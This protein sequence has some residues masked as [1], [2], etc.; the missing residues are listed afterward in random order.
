MN[1]ADALF[2]AD[3]GKPLVDQTG[4]PG[5]GKQRRSYFIAFL[6]AAVVVLAA[7]VGYYKF[8]LPDGV[9]AVVNTET[10]TLSELDAAVTRMRGTAGNASDGLRYQAL[11]ELIAERLV[12]QEAGKAGIRLSKEEADSAAR[13]AQAASGLDDAAFS[14]E[15]KVLYGSMQDF[16]KALERRLVIN[17]FIAERVVPRGADPQAAAQAVNQWLRNLSGKASI[18]IALAENL[19]SGCCGPGG[20][21]RAGKGGAASASARA[22]EDAGLRYWHAKHGPDNVSTR[23]RDFGCHIQVDI[24]K[25]EKIISSLRYQDGNI[26][27]M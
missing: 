26:T 15:M 9:A 21:C 16:Q 12:L 4:R 14:R 24:L 6:F 3:C 18:R 19:G 23:L 11:N 10:I 13:D 1:D 2:C 5:R 22:A 20:G 27:E 8:L 17:R 7:A 25:N